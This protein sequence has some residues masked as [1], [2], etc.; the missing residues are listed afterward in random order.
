MEEG[1]REGDR[2]QAEVAQISRECQYGGHGIGRCVS[3]PCRSLEV[4]GGMRLD[5]RCVVRIDEA[6]KTFS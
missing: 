2:W 6:S 3:C 5:W 4:I 1:W